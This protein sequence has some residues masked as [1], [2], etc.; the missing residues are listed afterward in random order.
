MIIGIVPE[1]AAANEEIC[2]AT[3]HRT[4][5]AEK[6]SI[7]MLQVQEIRIPRGPKFRDQ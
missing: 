7:V 5:H 6:A 2:G 3:L 4:G 1:M